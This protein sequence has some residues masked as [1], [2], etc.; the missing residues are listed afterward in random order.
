MKLEEQDRS[1][2]DKCPF[3][4][5]AMSGAVLLLR[6]LYF[7]LTTLL[8]LSLLKWYGFTI[9]TVEDAIQLVEALRWDHLFP[10]TV[11]LGLFLF[12]KNLS[13][14]IDRLRKAGVDKGKSFF[15]FDPILS[16]TLAVSSGTDGT[17]RLT[18]DDVEEV[19]R[20]VP[21]MNLKRLK[22][23][24]RTAHSWFLRNGV[25]TREQ[26]SVLAAATAI[27]EFLSQ[28]YIAELKRDPD[29]PLDPVAMA[30]WGVSLFVYGLRDDVK[31]GI[32]ARVRMSP[33]YREQHQ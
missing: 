1:A 10:L 28:I 8:V 23:E 7:I 33:E 15:E 21:G 5:V 24:A 4:L 13:R 25:T 16:H 11:V 12:K 6:I 9:W 31:D 19:L 30:T 18:V 29:K 14:L 2:A 3:I 26:L 20:D 32:V 27:S 17:P 22:K